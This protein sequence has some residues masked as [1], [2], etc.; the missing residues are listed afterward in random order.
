MAKPRLKRR[1]VLAEALRAPP[2]AQKA[3]RTAL[4]VDHEVANR[5]RDAA[6]WERR[7]VKDMAEEA[8]LEYVERLESERG[9][10]YPPRPKK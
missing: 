8:L 9:E 3:G 2:P 7:S 5:L 6:H 10:P 4:G 1:N